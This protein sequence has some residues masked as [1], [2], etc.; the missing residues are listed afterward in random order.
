[1]KRYVSL[2]VFGICFG[3]ALNPGYG[4]AQNV[5]SNYQFNNFTAGDTFQN[6]PGNCAIIFSQWT[7]GL[8]I[9]H[10]NSSSF[11]DSDHFDSDS[12]TQAKDSGDYIYF[13]IVTDP[14]T[15]LTINQLSFRTGKSGSAD[16][17]EVVI[18]Y[19]SFLGGFSFGPVGNYIET[20]IS[21]SNHNILL[22]PSVTVMPNDSALFRLVIINDLGHNPHGYQPTFK[23]FKASIDAQFSYNLASLSAQINA[24]NTHYCYQDSAFINIPV[25]LSGTPLATVYYNRDGMG[26]S[27]VLNT[28]GT[29]DLSFSET[30][31]ASGIYVY[32]LDSI[33]S[34]CYT[35]PLNQTFSITVYPPV[36]AVAVGLQ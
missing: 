15:T 21:G 16:T 30:L 19:G 6:I 8:G 1:M 23:L 35:K 22:T 9:E 25:T 14:Y 7:R 12:Y 28:A 34:N 10:V 20:S 32:Q 4:Y 17:A 36:P 5:L 3:E 33:R 13:S 2:L 11:F 29:A 27:A 31:P 26:D 18:D 24:P